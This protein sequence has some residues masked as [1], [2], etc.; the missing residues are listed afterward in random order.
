[1]QKYCFPVARVFF[2][3]HCENVIHESMAERNNDIITVLGM[4]ACLAQNLRCQRIFFADSYKNYVDLFVISRQYFYYLFNCFNYTD[5]FLI[6]IFFSFMFFFCCKFRSNISNM[7]LRI[8]ECQ[9]R[10]SISQMQK[11]PY[12]FSLIFHFTLKTSDLEIKVY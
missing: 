3:R 5:L 6:Y 7:S 12:F 8:A 10:C 1:M 2:T 11:L 4:W 9:S